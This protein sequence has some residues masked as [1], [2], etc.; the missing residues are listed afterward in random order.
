[1]GRYAC[2]PDVFYVICA[3]DDDGIN[4]ETIDATINEEV[5]QEQV[6]AYAFEEAYED[7][8]R[9][10]QSRNMTM[11]KVIYQVRLECTRYFYK[12]VDLRKEM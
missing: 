4:F 2:F 5:A 6:M 3:W 7:A 8:M 10:L 1:M 9:E 11:A 12:K